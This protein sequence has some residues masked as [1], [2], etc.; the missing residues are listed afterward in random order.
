MLFQSLSKDDKLM[1]PSKE[2]FRDTLL[3][4]IAENKR[5]KKHIYNDADIHCI[6]NTQR[7]RKRTRRYKKGGTSYDD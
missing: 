1:T 3:M 6:E 5:K 2:E 7:I 4:L